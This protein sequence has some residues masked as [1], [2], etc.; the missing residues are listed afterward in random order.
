MKTVIVNKKQFNVLKENYSEMNKEMTFFAFLSHVK[1]YLK[2]L[3]TNPINTT[4]DMFLISYGLDNPKLLTNLLDNNIIIKSEKIIN[5]GDNDK[6]SIS[7]KIPRENFERKM[8]RL[9]SNLFETNIIE[10]T[11]LTEDGEGAAMGG[12]S[13]AACN[14]SAPI[15]PL[16]GKPIRRK[17]YVTKEQYDRLEKI[18]ESTVM[19]TPIGDFG[20]DAPPFADKN[21]PAYDHNNMMKKSFNYGKK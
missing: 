3:L 7:Y 17:I 2:Q 6:F 11:T 18:K 9:Y 16:F 12:T 8:K 13:A 20:Y 1:S 19:N 10:G 4:P 5:D 15:T 14:D 21:D